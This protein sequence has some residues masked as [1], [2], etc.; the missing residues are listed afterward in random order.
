MKQVLQLEEVAIT[1][2]ACYFLSEHLLGMAVGWWVLLF[3]APDISMLGYAINPQVGAISYNLFHHRGLALLLT[4]SGAWWS[5][6]PLLAT[7]ILLFAHA[8]FDRI[9]GYGLKYFKGFGYTH[10]G[11]V[12]KHAQTA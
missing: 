12:G 6:E 10:L 3:F 7:G 2:V 9:W 11:Q 4:A 5:I 1:A 8:S